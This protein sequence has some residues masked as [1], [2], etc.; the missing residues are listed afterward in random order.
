MRRN[1]CLGRYELWRLFLTGED[2]LP[3]KKLTSE[4]TAR[5]L[6]SPHRRS[7][8]NRPERR[9]RIH[10]YWNE[11]YLVAVQ[12]RPRGHANLVA[13]ALGALHGHPE[14]EGFHDVFVWGW[15]ECQRPSFLYTK[16][17]KVLFKIDT[18]NYDF[19]VI[20]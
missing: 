6:R 7:A 2:H 9:V 4:T 13:G 11:D 17:K 12:Y 15:H 10:R 19:S 3:V 20:P 8:F 14:P 18:V 1:I 5:E 16:V